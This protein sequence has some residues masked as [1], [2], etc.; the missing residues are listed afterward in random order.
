MDVAVIGTSVG[1]DV[2]HCQMLDDAD[3]QT[4]CGVQSWL[5]LM[6]TM[7]GAWLRRA[8]GGVAARR[9]RW[10][11]IWCCRSCRRLGLSRSC[12]RM[13]WRLSKVFLLCMTKIL[14]EWP[15]ADIMGHQA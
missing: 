10:M 4:A 15:E 1:L 11:T 14:V 9:V 5:H 7:T 3:V 8:D 2:I 13:S 12:L 6:S